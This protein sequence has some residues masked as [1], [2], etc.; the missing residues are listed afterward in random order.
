MFLRKVGRWCFIHAVLLFT[1]VPGHSEQNGGI[2]GNMNRV[3]ALTSVQLQYSFLNEL[4]WD[5]SFLL[6]I[7]I[8]CRMCSPRS[9]SQHVQNSWHQIPYTVW[10]GRFTDLTVL[11]CAFGQALILKNDKKSNRFTRQ[12]E[13]GY[14]MGI[15][16]NSKGWLIWNV[17][18]KKYQIRFNIRVINNMMWKPV[19]SC[20]NKEIQPAGPM[21]ESSEQLQGQ[22]VL[23]L[24]QQT[25]G[26][27][28]DYND[29]VIAFSD[30]HGQPVKVVSFMDLHSNELSC[31]YVPGE[32]LPD[33]EW[34]DEQMALENGDP[35]SK[36]EG[37]LQ[38]EK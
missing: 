29:E 28:T 23:G 30:V 31:Y 4:F 9:S 38:E 12:G 3:M 19:V 33:G 22:N 32:A 36:E 6:A 2:E 13:L 21:S 35:E 16:W 11:I 14:F 24:L 37:V 8:L 15:P 17:V 26:D 1:N 5:R 7:F 20:L 34:P 25:Y 18:Q 10:S 27:K